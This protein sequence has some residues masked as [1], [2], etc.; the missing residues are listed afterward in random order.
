MQ[1]EAL[2]LLLPDKVF[3]SRNA[4]Y[5]QSLHSYYAGQEGDLQPWCIVKPA[6]VADVATAVKELTKASTTGN[7]SCRFAVRGGGHTSFAG[8]A[9]IVNGVTID[10]RDINHVSVSADQ[11]LTSV[12][13]GARWRDV[14]SKLDPLGL[15]VSGGRADIVGVGGLSLGGMRQPSSRRLCPTNRSSGGLS[16]F[17]PRKG[18]VCDNVLNYQV[19]LANGTIIDVNTKHNADLMRALRGG[20]NNFGIVTRFDLNTFVQGNVWGGDIIYNISTAPEQLRA[21][22]EFGVNPAY[23]EYAALFQIFGFTRG[24]SVAMNRLIYT[25][26][27]P[28]PPVFQPF[29]SI[30][31]QLVRTLQVANIGF[32]TNDTSAA[33]TGLR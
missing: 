8:S 25:K 13:G 17:S 5:W 6:D 3:Y 33:A 32:F 23:D 29:T 31:P 19:V 26:P 15:S 12:G 16:F 10:L 20:S 28:N 14:Y 24:Q 18:F 27:D 4:T 30:Q 22:V 2:S 11:T 9:N 21:F 7:D 1:C